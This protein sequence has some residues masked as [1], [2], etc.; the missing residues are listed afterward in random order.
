MT[1]FY[2]YDKLSPFM[3]IDDQSQAMK[4]SYDQLLPDMASWYHFQLVMTTY[5]KL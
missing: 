4:T 3:T 5:E 1:S 2:N